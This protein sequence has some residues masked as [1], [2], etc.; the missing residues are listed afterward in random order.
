[1]SQLHEPTF[2]VTNIKLTVTVIKQVGRINYP[3][4][5]ILNVTYLPDNDTAGQK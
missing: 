1:M 4:D 2:S 5:V 3:H